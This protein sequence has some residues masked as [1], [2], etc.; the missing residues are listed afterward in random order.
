MYKK[1]ALAASLAL[2]AGHGVAATWNSAAPAQ[3]AVTHTLQGI[4]DV[5]ESTGVVNTNTLLVLGAEYA[6][7]DTITFTNT[8]AKASDANWPTSLATLKTTAATAT[9]KA[10]VTL[11]AGATT[12]TTAA[13]A[14]FVIGDAFTLTTDSTGTI[15]RVLTKANTSTFS[16]TPGLAESMAA[17]VDMAK[18]ETQVNFGLVNSDTK[19]ATYRVTTITDAASSINLQLMAP[20]LAL[21]PSG[22]LTATQ[23]DLTFAASTATGLS[24]DANTTAYTTADTE[25]EYTFSVTTKFDGVVDVENDRKKFT[26]ATTDTGGTAGT[27]SLYRDTMIYKLALSTGTNGTTMTSA[28]AA[29]AVTAVNATEAGSVL[30]LGGDF[31]FLDTSTAAGITPAGS[32]IIQS[33]G[34]D[35]TPVGTDAIDSTSGAITVTQANGT[36]WGADTDANLII[37]SS[38]TSNALPVQSYTPSVTM[39][40]QS[41]S[42][43]GNTK[44]LTADAGSWTLNGASI[45][46]YM[47]PWS[48][49]T[50]K[51]LWVGNTGAGDAAVSATVQAGGADYGPYSVGT[52]A[53]KSQGKINAALDSALSTAGVDTSTWSRANVTVTAPVKASDITLSASY[54]HVGD[55]D[56]LTIETSDTL[57]GTTK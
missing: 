20:N 4:E 25:E 46:A 28:S 33:D 23:N 39:T 24:M 37:T 34:S 18:H 56:R 7:N 51:Y 54:K 40:Y 50:E 1:T 10:G 5:V 14:A 45:T 57:D 49:A 3:S 27:A 42:V 8:V 6:V 52:V 9:T 30:T 11:A 2:I 16:F 35:M 44:T 48:S 43:T 29:A 15:Y 21:S 53:S 36:G 12:L 55:A 38:V 32:A 31:S 41:G 47:V 13:S 17:G 19:S 26:V 22:L